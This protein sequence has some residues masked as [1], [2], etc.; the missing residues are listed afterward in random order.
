MNA[1]H[2]D[3]VRLYATGLLGA[4]DWPWRL[5]GIDPDGLD[6]ACGDATLRLPFA[7]RVTTAEQ[8]RRVVVDLANQARAGEPR[9][10]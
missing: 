7:E 1:D 5:T 2:A 10:G 9:K 3:A 8:L 6:L 4:D